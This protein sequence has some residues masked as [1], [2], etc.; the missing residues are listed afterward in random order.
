MT[1]IG[2]IGITPVDN[3]LS[4]P[5]RLAEPGT[6]QEAKPVEPGANRLVEDGDR[7]EISEHARHLAKIKAIPDVRPDRVEAARAALEN[8]SL[9]TDEA[10]RNALEIMISESELL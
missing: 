1:N 8:G 10:L 9:D 2:H 7:V 4:A 5:G 6:D 3:P